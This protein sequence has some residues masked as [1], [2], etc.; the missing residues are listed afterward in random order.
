MTLIALQYCP[1]IMN[2]S[3]CSEYFFK[4]IFFVFWV[5]GKREDEIMRGSG[6]G[7]GGVKSMGVDQFT[8]GFREPL[9]EDYDL[10]R[11]CTE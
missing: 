11:L 9:G 8:L 6:V 2:H 1:V 7:W 10:D 3:S 5:R 4:S